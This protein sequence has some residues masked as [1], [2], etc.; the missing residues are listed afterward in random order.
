[1]IDKLTVEQES[2]LPVYRDKWIA[3]GLSTESANRPRA[4]AGII[5]AYQTAKLPPP[6]EII[7]FD[8][9]KTM[10][11]YSV[12][13]SVRNS[14]G[15]S[16][17]NSVRDSVG[18][19]VW[20]SVWDSVGDSVW[21]SVWDSVGNSVWD[22]VG[23]SVRDSV[24]ASVRDSVGASVWDS[25]GASVWAYVWDSVVNSVGWGHHE[26]SNLSFYDYIGEVLGLQD[27]VAPLH[28]LMEIAKSAGWWMPYKDICLISERPCEL[29]R[30]HQGI[31]HK[32]GGMAIK[33]PDEWGIWCLNGV[34]VP[35]HIAESKDSD[36]KPEWFTKETNL[37]VRR[38]VIRK[39]GVERVMEHLNAKVVDKDGDYELLELNLGGDITAR[40]LKMVNPSIGTYH[41]EFVTPQCDTVAKALAFRN[42]S[43][44]TPD[45][46]T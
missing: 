41:I 11:E 37:E 42:G 36:F 45:I 27:K 3:I 16:V 15:A 39:F 7:W 5:I 43:D 4:E 25:V 19:S 44:L 33:Y 12:G 30:N 20:N 31:L 23:A 6:K 14:V 32:D 1:M 38:E 28:G 13:N 22:S 21:N 26:A 24:G 46:L 17:G 35:Q 34:I 2:L 10:I 40:A 29:Y 8:S 9:P 18:D